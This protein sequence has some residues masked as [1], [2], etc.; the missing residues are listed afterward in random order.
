MDKS[1]QVDFSDFRTLDSVHLCKVCNIVSDNLLPATFVQLYSEVR[2]TRNKIAHLNAGNMK[3]ES[4][5]ILMKILTAHKQLY[6]KETWMD[7]RRNYML[8]QQHNAPQWDVDD[9]TN[10]FLNYE[11]EALRWS[12]A[13]RH[14]L[15]FFGYDV[16]KR[17]LRCYNCE[18]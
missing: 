17:A 10:D 15:E 18:D 13:P 8:T 9:S 4:T 14:L 3:T 12:L 11:F 2:K 6:N 5:D 7:F 16:R 1:G